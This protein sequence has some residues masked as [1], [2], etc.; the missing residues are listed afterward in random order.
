MLMDPNW[1]PIMAI[2]HL[3]LKPRTLL[4]IRLHKNYKQLKLNTYLCQHCL[5]PAVGWHLSAAVV[6][7]AEKKKSV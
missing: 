7:P 1:Q 2:D 3:D 4:T 6:C 5:L